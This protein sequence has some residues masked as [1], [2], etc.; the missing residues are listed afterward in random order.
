MGNSRG[1]TEQAQVS[2]FGNQLQNDEAQLS[3]HA[4]NRNDHEDN[5]ME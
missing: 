4:P 3:L 2:A 1:Q 5:E